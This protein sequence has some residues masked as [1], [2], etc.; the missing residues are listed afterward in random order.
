MPGP[1]ETDLAALA[2]RTRALEDRAAEDRGAA[3][4][5]LAETRAETEREIEA[6]R[7]DLRDNY[8]TADKIALAYPSIA[9]Q[10]DTVRRHQAW[11]LYFVGLLAAADSIANL[12]HLLFAR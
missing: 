8:L 1:A 4:R 5:M 3:M 11:G 6:I 9:G 7:R 2:V 12:L 10:H